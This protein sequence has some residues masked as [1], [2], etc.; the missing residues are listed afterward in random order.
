MV[1]VCSSFPFVF[2][3]CFLILWLG[4]FFFRVSCVLVS[5]LE[6][7]LLHLHPCVFDVFFPLVFGILLVVLVVV[8]SC[9]F[10]FY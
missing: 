5:S 7:S 1:H 10:V 4:V 2:R 3:L 6:H 8:R 9:F